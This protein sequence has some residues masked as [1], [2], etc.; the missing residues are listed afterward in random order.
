MRR[1]R[2]EIKRVYGSGG[3][4]VGEMDVWVVSLYRKELEI[5]SMELYSILKKNP[6]PISKFSKIKMAAHNTIQKMP[7]YN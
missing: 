3:R 1:L 6:L 4:R 5:F 7:Y 2:V